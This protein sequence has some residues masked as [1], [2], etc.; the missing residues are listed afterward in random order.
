MSNTTTQIE[1]FGTVELADGTHVRLI[2]QAY[3]DNDSNGDAAW[4]ANGYLST[5]DAEDETGPTVKV[6]W[7]SLGNDEA[8]DDADWSAPKSAVHYSRGELALK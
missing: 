6:T 3:S 7:T 8:E 2:Q 4:F 5:E 1:D